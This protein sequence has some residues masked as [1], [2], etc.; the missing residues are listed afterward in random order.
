[1]E[2]KSSTQIKRALSAIE[3][4]KFRETLQLLQEI[5]A[6]HFLIGQKLMRA[7]TD[8]QLLKYSLESEEPLSKFPE[9]E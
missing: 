1:M 5:A 8:L 3:A 6:M 9:A 7:S 2:R 4:K